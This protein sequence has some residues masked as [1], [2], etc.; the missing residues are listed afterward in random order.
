MQITWTSFAVHLKTHTTEP[1]VKSDQNLVHLALAGCSCLSMEQCLLVGSSYRKKTSC[2]SVTFSFLFPCAIY[3]HSSAWENEWIYQKGT[4]H[5]RT[6]MT[7]HLDLHHGTPR[8][9]RLQSCLH[10]STVESLSMKLVI[11]FTNVPVFLKDTMLPPLTTLRW[12]CALI[13]PLQM[14]MSW[15]LPM[16]FMSYEWVHAHVMLHIAVWC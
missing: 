3:M 14:R 5:S 7:A 11:M 9:F 13:S 8:Q 16:R 1:W 15:S 4:T 10:C 6:T 2:L 12:G